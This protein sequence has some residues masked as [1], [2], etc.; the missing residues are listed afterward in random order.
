MYKQIYLS[1]VIFYNVNNIIMNKYILLLII[2]LIL[3]TIYFMV[4]IN[5]KSYKLIARDEKYKY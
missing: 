3:I 4:G 5:D 1:I 2:I